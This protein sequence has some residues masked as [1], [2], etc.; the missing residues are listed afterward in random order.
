[1]S[2]ECFLIGCPYSTSNCMSQGC[3][4]IEEVKKHAVRARVS[5]SYYN[6]HY[7]ENEYY[8]EDRDEREQ[9][10][11]I[12]SLLEKNLTGKDL[13]VLLLVYQFVLKNPD[14]LSGLISKP[15]ASVVDEVL[16]RVKI[17]GA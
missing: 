1:M 3:K 15:I 13:I 10:M 2:S 16:K 11:N 17:D 4:H 6:A 12:Q 9:N 14:L 7:K 5:D 8:D